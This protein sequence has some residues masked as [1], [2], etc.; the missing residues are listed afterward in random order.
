[1]TSYEIALL[2][3]GALGGIGAVI[4]GR[5]TQTRIVGPVQNVMAGRISPSIRRLVTMLLHVSTVTWLAGGVALIVI[6]LA[7]APEARLSSGLLV[8]SSYLVATLGNLWAT[9]GRHPG[10]VLYGTACVLTLY[11]LLAPQ[12]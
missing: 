4:H 11:G 1:M 9:R 8:A 10:W 2:G 5:L 6:A 3:A 7:V 12:A